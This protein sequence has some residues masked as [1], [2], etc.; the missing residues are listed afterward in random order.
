VLAVY[1]HIA[2]MVYEGG[3]GGCVTVVI[4]TFLCGLEWPGSG[5]ALDYAVYSSSCVALILVFGYSFL[6]YRGGLDSNIA[7]SWRPWWVVFKFVVSGL[8]GS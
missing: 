8:V 2:F 3:L 4:D 5:V 7:L 1:G 6:V